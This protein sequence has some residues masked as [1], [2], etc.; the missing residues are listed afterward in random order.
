M[1]MRRSRRGGVLLGSKLEIGINDADDR[2]LIAPELDPQNLLRGTGIIS[3]PLRRL[4]AIHGEDAGLDFLRV[5]LLC[6]SQAIVPRPAVDT[7]RLH[8]EILA[9]GNFRVKSEDVHF[10]NV[11]DVDHGAWICRGAF[12]AHDLRERGRVRAWAVDVL[13]AFLDELGL[14]DEETGHDVADVEMGSLG[15]HEVLGRVE[16]FHFAGGVALEVMAVWSLGIRVG[17]DV[18]GG[19][20]AVDFLGDEITPWDDGDDGA[21]DYHAFHAGAL[22]GGFENVECALDGGFDHGFDHIVGRFSER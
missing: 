4:R 10:G 19:E 3:Q 8:A 7:A 1:A 22:G 15:A 6:D 21:G 18:V 16:C 13:L 5:M 2:L 9:S 14:A 17:D 11:V 12:A 20:D